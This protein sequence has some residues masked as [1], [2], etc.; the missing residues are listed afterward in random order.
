MR[1]EERH[2]TVAPVVHKAGWGVV[3]VEGQHRHQ[4]HGGDAQRLQVRDLLDQSGVR[5]RQAPVDPAVRVHRESAHMQFVDD[6]ARETSLEGR[7][8]L[9]VEQVEV[10]HHTLH[11][12]SRI[13]A[14]PGARFAVVLSRDSH[15]DAVRVEQHS[16]RVVP[17]SGGRIEHAVSAPGVHLPR[18]HSGHEHMP[19]VR[20]A[21]ALRI[22]R[23]P[24]CG[25]R[26]LDAVEE[27]QIH[28]RCGARPHREVRSRGTRMSAQGMGAACGRAAGH[29]ISLSR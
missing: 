9:P 24:P 2:R 15:R 20:G 3:G 18:T 19:E 29:V 7:I 5:T 13:P 17:Q 23:D 26:V 11:G 8:A 4:L 1:G 16:R 14:T 6:R 10:R 25:P 22:Q 28:L 21:V 12:G 27:Q